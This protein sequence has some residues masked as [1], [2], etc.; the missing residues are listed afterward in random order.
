L[1]SLNRGGCVPPRT[2]LNHLTLWALAAACL[3]CAAQAAPDA[4]PAASEQPRFDVWEIQVEGSALIPATVIEKAVYPHLGPDRDID[5][6][7][8]ARTAVESA[9]REAGF[10]TVLVNIPEQD[11]DNGIVRLEV[12]EGR[13]ERLRVIGSRYFSLGRI[14]SGV[15]SLANGRSPNL[16]QVQRELAALNKASPDRKI[17]PVLKPGRSPGTVDVDLKVEDK[18]PVHGGLELN[19]E[20]IR[21]TTRLRL[22]ASLRY[23]NLWQREHSAGVSFQLT[24]EDP[25]EVK[26]FSGTYLF[27]PGIQDLLVVLYGVKS[28]S[29]VT[30]LGG[31]GGGVGVLGNGVIVGAR[32]IKPLPTLGNV[33]HNLTLGLDY[34]DFQDTVSPVNGTGFETPISYTKFNVGYGGF[35]IDE[36]H[37]IRFNLDG[38]FGVRGL[39]N[40][41]QEFT[42][43]RFQDT[44]NYFYLRGDGAWEGTLYAGAELL[45]EFAGQVSSGPIIGN[46]QFSI[47]GASSVRG[48]FETQGL[49]DH[50]VN[51]RLELRSPSL[52]GDIESPW[53][54]A[55]KLASFVEAGHGRTVD[56][57]PG[58][59][60]AFSLAST[61]LGLRLAAPHGLSSR[62]DWAVPLIENS[63]IRAFESRFHFSFGYEF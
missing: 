50:G 29:E 30:A 49:V 18:L 51:G 43:K 1:S 12:L 60:E 11:V 8:A 48:Y 63:E 46:E 31:G 57:L 17:S 20:F 37:T 22:N 10:A 19:D 42:N 41:V 25:S 53:L 54:T 52:I 58:Q 9:F 24:P 45:L 44:P 4:A 27:R 28:A 40:T 38:N 59:D 39:G 33:Y 3:T 23:D 15:P 34:K 6:V 56:P 2:L 35:V 36:Q 7:E 13:V 14:K 5:D 47:G 61:G 62:I 55:L 32:V 21:N 26:V 16:P